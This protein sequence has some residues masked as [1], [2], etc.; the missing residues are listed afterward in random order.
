MLT[1]EDDVEIHA[2]P[3]QPPCADIAS[4]FADPNG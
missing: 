4:R 3:T 1:E 2:N